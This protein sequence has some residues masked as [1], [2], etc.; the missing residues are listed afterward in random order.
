M[1]TPYAVEDEKA[2]SKNMNSYLLGSKHAQP[3]RSIAT[4]C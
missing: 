4:P 1:I 3:F 2:V